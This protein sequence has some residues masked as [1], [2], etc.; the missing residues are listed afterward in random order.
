MLAIAA[1]V[2]FGVYFLSDLLNNNFGVPNLIN[3]PT[4]ASLGLL[5]LSLYLAGVG[6]GPATGSGSGRRF[7]GRRPG[8][9]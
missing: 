1:A 3:F 7:Y 5:L 4:M 6:R 9:G 8:R 2:V